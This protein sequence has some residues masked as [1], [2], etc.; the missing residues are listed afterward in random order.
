MPAEGEVA[1]LMSDVWDI[2]NRVSGLGL[3]ES[4]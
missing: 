3:S 1:R 2:E 4:P